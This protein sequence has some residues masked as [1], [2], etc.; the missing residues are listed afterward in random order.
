MTS[1]TDE[2]FESFDHFK[3]RQGRQKQTAEMGRGVSS[4]LGVSG[5]RFDACRRGRRK[6]RARARGRG[7]LKME[8]RIGSTVSPGPGVLRFFSAVPR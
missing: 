4:L 2:S 5:W 8:Y 6:G 7:K 1:F 3:A